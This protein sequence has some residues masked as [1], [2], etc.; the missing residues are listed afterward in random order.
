MVR[1]PS[2]QPGKRGRHSTASRLAVESRVARLHLFSRLSSSASPWEIIVDKLSAAGWSRG[3]I[4]VLSPAMAGAGSLMPI[5]ET[6]AATSVQSDELLSAFLEL[7]RVT[8]GQ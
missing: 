5:A 3:V 8:I 1:D 2:R 7:E 6:V 4:A